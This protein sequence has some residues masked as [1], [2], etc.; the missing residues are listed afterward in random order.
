MKKVISVLGVGR[1]AA[2]TDSTDK[3]AAG[4]DD[5]CSAKEMRSVSGK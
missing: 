4:Q 2:G 5:D 1:S 3:Y